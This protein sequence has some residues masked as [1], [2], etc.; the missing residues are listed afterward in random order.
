MNTE[1]LKQSK[2][3]NTKSKQRSSIPIICSFL[4]EINLFVCRINL[5][6]KSILVIHFFGL[7]GKARETPRMY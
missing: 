3:L 6:E 1:I 7:S 2:Q 5:A 4:K